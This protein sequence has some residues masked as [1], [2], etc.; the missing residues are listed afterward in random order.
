MSA[1]D[2][3][4]FAES[5]IGHYEFS[6]EGR[7]THEYHPFLLAK[8]SQSLSDL[9]QRLVQEKFSLLGRMIIMGYEENAVP[10]YYTNYKHSGIDD[11]ALRKSNV[12]WSQRLHNRFGCMTGFLFKDLCSQHP[13]FEHID[14][15]EMFIFDDRATIFQEHAFGEALYCMQQE[16]EIVLKKLWQQTPSDVLKELRAFWQ[17]LYSHAFKV[18]NKQ[19]AATQDALFSIEYARYLAESPLPVL[20]FFTGPDITYPIEVTAKQDR[21]ATLHAQHFAARMARELQ[22]HQGSN[23]AYVF[24]SFVDGVGKSTMLGNIKNWTRWGDEVE[25][26][27]HVDNSSSQVC[28]LFKLK[29]G[30]FIADLP[31]QVS[32]FTYKPDGLVYV[33]AR[34]LRTKNELEEIANFVMQHRDDLIVQSVSTFADVKKIIAAQGGN[35]AA[36][37]D[38]NC[39]HVAFA[40]NVLLLGHE[41]SNR[42]VPFCYKGENFLFKNADSFELRCLVPLAVVKSEGLKNIEAEQMLFFDGIRFP[43]PYTDFLDDFVAKLKAQGI[44]SVV[45]VDFLSMYPR[46][47][48]ENVRINYLMQQMALLDPVFCPTLSLYRD[49]V[50]GGELLFALMHRKSVAALQQ[51]FELETMVRMMLFEL[52]NNRTHGDLTGYD[53]VTLTSILKQRCA[54]APALCRNAIRGAVAHKMKHETQQLERTYG[55]S[56]SFVNVQ[57]F[58]L[59]KVMRYWSLLQELFTQRVAHEYLPAVWQLPGTLPPMEH[60]L[61][62]GGRI[63]STIKTEQGT[64]VQG[65]YIVHEM[66]KN[67]S[68][69]KP[70]IRSLRAQWY[71]AL[72]GLLFSTDEGSGTMRI[73][74]EQPGYAPLMFIPGGNNFFYVVQRSYQTWTNKIPSSTRS[75]F[76]LFNLTNF[77]AA[78]YRSVDDVPCRYDWECGTTCFGLFSFD[79]VDTKENDEESKYLTRSAISYL[80][81]DYQR[82]YGEQIVMPAEDLWKEASASL[83]WQ[84]E[85]DQLRTYAARKGPRPSTGASLSGYGVSTYLGTEEQKTV[86]RLVVRLLATLE[87]IL[88]DPEADIAVRD[89]NHED[90]KAALKLFER[91]VLPRYFKMTFL[92]DLFD[93]YDAVEPYPSWDFWDHCDKED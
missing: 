17:F 84:H 46:S 37:A 31:A 68:V 36:L 32:H 88:K 76:Q 69:L 23:T 18:G 11:E 63:S 9:A 22:P 61:V 44:T 6:L 15:D 12:G 26:F 81:Q 49:F 8:T 90:F 74:P 53:M 52:I 60:G 19:I 39:P 24:C 50:S 45:F 21:Y 91:V 64:M 77:R 92:T 83:F 67:E 13:V 58:S 78:A 47:S 89:G 57:H 86:V 66:C 2:T 41:K 3:A 20:K 16:R 82:E 55:L 28:D 25:H 43:Y 40:R 30:V 38:K 70:L 79:N 34:T 35:A 14:H 10:T 71:A 72:A 29:E 7:Y 80:V 48:R 1:T 75:F 51:A 27:E 85:Y 73:D 54:D 42:W 93:D 33:D 62:D 4:S 5:F 87:M 56:K 59:H 65:R